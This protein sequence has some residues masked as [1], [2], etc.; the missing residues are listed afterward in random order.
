MSDDDQIEKMPDNPA[1]QAPPKTSVAVEDKKPAKDKKAAKGDDSGNG[2]VTQP[3]VKASAAAEKDD[4][5]ARKPFWTWDRFIDL[6]KI[7]ATLYAACI[8]TIVTMQFNERQHELARIEAIAQL[9]PHLAH[10]EVQHSAP[11]PSNAASSAGQDSAASSEDRESRLVRDGTMW[12][13]FRTAQNKTMLRDLA[14][15]FPEDVYRVVGS[16]AAADA[17]EDQDGITALEV[18]SEKMA[19]R[20]AAEGKSG[21]AGRLYDQ[22]LRL[23]KH[24]DGTSTAPLDIIDLTNLEH[25]DLRKYKDN[26]EQ[27]L[28]LMKS[29][30][31]LAEAH[32]VESET[33][34]GVNTTHSDAKTFYMHAIE[35]GKQ[36]AESR[37]IQS[38]LSKS[39]D[40]MSKICLQENNLDGAIRWMRER[41]KVEQTSLEPDDQAVAQCSR[42][43]ANLLRKENPHSEEA[44]T[45]ITQAEALM[46]KA[47]T[48]PKN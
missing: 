5:P 8:G 28:D 23:K 29:A 24:E 6:L 38:E 4:K 47:K 10:S 48:E 15:L 17:L 35:A 42:D 14:A 18:A 34:T 26:D 1:P 13:I 40:G 2:T 16:I 19:A 31:R 11:A 41:L 44:K 32:V 21:L 9:L 37:A 20:Y 43:L 22:A 30:N 25:F 39:Y 12:A 3:E 45:L 33:A 46:A 36:H 27:V 7:L